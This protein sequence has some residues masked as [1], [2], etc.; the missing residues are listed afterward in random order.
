MNIMNLRN[1][2]FYEQEE[3]LVCFCAEQHEKTPSASN[4]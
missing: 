3:F 1:S 2:I 4:L